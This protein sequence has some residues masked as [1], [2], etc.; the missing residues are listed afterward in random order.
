MNIEEKGKEQAILDAAEQEFLEKGFDAAKTTH[1][2]ARAGV[3]HALLHY[4]YRTKENLFNMILNQKIELLKYSI[5]S[6]LGDSDMSFLERVR[7]AIEI[8]FD[9]LAKNPQ[10][11]RFLVNELIHKPMRMKILEEPIRQIVIPL[12]EKA[13]QMIDIEVER[14][15]INPISASMLLIDIASLNIFTFAAL[16]IVRLVT[17]PAYINDHAFFEAR[18]QENVEIIMRRLQCK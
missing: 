16:P 9:F 7:T 8:H 18:K 10:L 2:A 13:Q 15:T 4:Y 12:L 17:T 5:I 1:I 11:P 6:L 3:T 14:G